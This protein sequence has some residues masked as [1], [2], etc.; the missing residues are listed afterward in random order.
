MSVSFIGAT[1]AEATSLTLPTHQAGDLLVMA[2]GKTGVS[3]AATV[4]AGWFICLTRADSVVPARRVVLAWKIAASDSE[5]SGT[6]TDAALL[7]C[8]VYRNDNYATLSNSS[9]ATTRASATVTYGPLVSQA[10]VNN[11]SKLQAANSLLLGVVLT[12]ENSGVS[13]TAPSGMTNRVALAGA[14]S[15]YVAVHDTGS[16]VASWSNTSV[17][18]ASEVNSVSVVAEILDTGIPKSGGSSRPVNPFQQQVIG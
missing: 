6:W 17:V 7:A 11:V 16:A 13:T 14:S 3:T 4:P 18:G 15:G 2:A 10:G 12:V 9:G 5:V 8:L 1:S